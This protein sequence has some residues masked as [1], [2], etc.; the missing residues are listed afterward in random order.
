MPKIKNILT[1]NIYNDEA[2]IFKANKFK[3]FQSF[4]F[5]KSNLITSFIHTKDIINTK[6]LI[7][8]S[9]PDEDILDLID[10]KAYEDLGLDEATSYIISST[11]I[12]SE[13]E[14]REFH[15]FVVEA[16]LL[17]NY[18]GEIVRETKYIDL[19]TPAP[20][21]LKSLYRNNIVNNSGVDCF[22]YFSKND[23]FIT[24]YKDGEYIYSKS[25]EYSLSHMYDL[26]CQKSDDKIDEKDF[27]YML[28][29]KGL[30]STDTHK[31]YEIL[32]ELFE[33]IVISMNDVLAYTK[34]AF[35]LDV[36]DLVYIGSAFG[37]IPGLDSYVNTYLGITTR[38]FDFNYNIST[39][40]EYIDQ[41]QSLMLLNAS[42]YLENDY[43]HVNLTLYPRAPSFLNRASG[44]FI[45]ATAAAIA[46]SLIYPIFHLLGAY[47]NDTKNSM[48][49][50][51]NQNLTVESNKYKAIL[52]KKTETIKALDKK[53]DRLQT[54][55]SAKTKTLTAIYNK[56][57]NYKL[58]SEIFYHISHELN[59]FDVHVDELSSEGDTLWIS[60]IGS[61]ERKITELIKY[62]SEKYFN[63]IR[64][65]DIEKIDKNHSTNHYSGVLKVEFK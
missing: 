12:F 50:K 45:V 10:I 49:T 29:N 40:A 61:D 44:Q 28:M 36:I 14:D 3:A 6:V 23:A 13:G 17:D 64:K 7:S 58:K 20:L 62:I 37:S 27:Y 30:D 25:L 16:N 15:I 54:Q 32:R 53:I 63:D 8:R 38:V 59:Q 31:Y 48:L 43:G 52:S 33:T 56:K 26:F 11:E 21:L 5:N 22:V 2:Y 19:I 42:D 47:T 9:I 34:R 41:L 24:F 65:I 35:K 51:Q 57:V 4:R 60:M 18:F 55:Y 1:L 39:N 46:L